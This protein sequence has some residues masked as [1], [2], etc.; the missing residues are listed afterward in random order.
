[1][2]GAASAL[3][4][5]EPIAWDPISISVS[6]DVL[7]VADC[8]AGGELTIEVEQEREG[9]WWTVLG[10]GAPIEALP[11]EPIRV[12]AALADAV[13]AEYAPPVLDDGLWVAVSI[14]Y[15]DESTGAAAFEI[16]REALKP[17]VWIQADGTLAAQP[18][19]PAS[20]AKG[21]VEMWRGDDGVVRV[22]V[23]PVENFGELARL[24]RSVPEEARDR[25]IGKLLEASFDV[26]DSIDGLTWDP[27]VER[28][29][30]ER[31]IPVE[32]R[33]SLDWSALLVDP[34]Q[35]SEV[36]LRWRLDVI[37]AIEAALVEASG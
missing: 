8:G 20:G 14:T 24:A 30:S 37:A 9:T 25:L 13:G 2:V 5:C 23:E 15:S 10:E 34:G 22:A 31:R 27:A 35:V 11:G 7:L 33:K 3:T 4:A 6:G 29:F 36:E 17:G 16:S 1:M 21:D 28:E 32:M 26:G 12:D 19:A 18:C